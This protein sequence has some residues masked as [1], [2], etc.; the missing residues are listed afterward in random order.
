MYD[1]GFNFI[2]MH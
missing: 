2:K 1:Q